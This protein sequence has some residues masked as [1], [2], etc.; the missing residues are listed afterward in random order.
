[1]IAV[2]Y[3]RAKP[4]CKKGKPCGSVC[5]PQKAKCRKESPQETNTG[6][7]GAIKAAGWAVAAAATAA[8]IGVPVATYAGV[9]SRYRE[10]FKESAKMAQSMAKDI[11]PINVKEKQHSVV[12]CVGGMDYG[13][14]NTNP[15]I[16]GRIIS[17]A[18]N[19]SL[20]QKD[21]G[22]KTIPISTQGSNLDKKEKPEG[23][24]QFVADG[25]K[26]TVYKNVVEQG[27]NKAAVRLAAQA[28]A[29]HDKYP[30]KQIVMFGTSMGG[31]IVNEAQEI[32]KQA[33]PS[34]KSKLKSM[35]VGTPYFG[36]TEPWG[37]TTEIA[38]HEDKFTTVLPTRSKTKL[39]NLKHVNTKST[40]VLHGHLLS[41]YF[42]SDE[43]K[44]HL[45]DFIY[46]DV[47]TTKNTKKDSANE[48]KCRTG[49]PC[50]EICIPKTHKCRIGSYSPAKKA[51]VEAVK[52]KRRQVAL[53]KFS[54]AIGVLVAFEAAV[55]ATNYAIDRRN[56]QTIAEEKEVKDDFQSDVDNF[57]DFRSEMRDKARS[58][59][60]GRGYTDIELVDDWY[61]GFPPTGYMQEPIQSENQELEQVKKSLQDMEKKWRDRA[62]VEHFN[63]I[64]DTAHSKNRKKAT[65]DSIAVTNPHY[66]KLIFQLK[67][68][69]NRVYTD[70]IDHFIKVEVDKANTITGLFRDGTKILEFTI[71]G[72]DITYKKAG[73]KNK[74]DSTYYD[75]L[76]LELT[77]RSDAIKKKDK[78][79]KGISCGAACVASNKS[80]RLKAN[81]IASFGELA[82]LRTTA[83]QVGGGTAPT[84]VADQDTYETNPDTGQ[85]Y[86]IRELKKKAS[87]KGVYRYSEMTSDQLKEALRATDK[88]P[89]QQERLG[90]TLTRERSLT[91]RAQRAGLIGKTK[92]EKQFVQWTRE[93][94]K[95]S[96]FAD[97]V[98]KAPLGW[99]MTATAAFL[100][101]TAVRTYEQ[102]KD[103]Y[104]QG[105]NDSARAAEARAVGMDT[106]RVSKEN[107]AFVVGGFN[108]LGH[109]SQKMRELLEE[110]PQL[111]DKNHYVQFDLKETDVPP[112]DGNKRNPDGSYS[113]GYLGYV[114]TRGVGQF[115]KDLTRQRNDDAVELAAQI[116]AHAVRRNA[117]NYQMAHK[118]KS[119]NIVSHSVGGEVVNQAMDILSKMKAVGGKS[120]PTGKE[121]LERVNIVHLSAPD[122][123]FTEN[124]PGNY[125]NITSGQDPFSWMPKRREKWVSTVK[126]NEPE[127]YIRDPEVR[128]Q[129][130]QGFG[131][132]DISAKQRERS[133]KT[134]SRKKKEPSAAK[135]KPKPKPKTKPQGTEQK[136]DAYWEAFN[137]VRLDAARKKAKCKTGKSCGDICIP[138][139]AECHNGLQKATMLAGVVGVAGLAAGA[140]VIALSKSNQPKQQSKPYAQSILD[141]QAQK[142]R[143]ENIRQQ[144]KEV[145]SQVK[146]VLKKSRKR[147]EDAIEANK[148]QEKIEW[149]RKKAEKTATT[150]KSPEPVVLP[151]PAEPE[152]QEPKEHIPRGKKIGVYQ[153]VGYSKSL[154]EGLNEWVDEYE[155]SDN[156]DINRPSTN[157]AQ[158][159]GMAD[160]LLLLAGSKNTQV[161]EKHLRGLVDKDGKLQAAASIEDR[162][163]HI[164]V[165]RLATAPWN[166]TKSQKSTKG[167]GTAMFEAIVREAA[168]Q[169][170]GIR[171][172]TTTSASDFYQ[173]MGLE[174][175]EATGMYYTFTP[176]Q[177]QDFLKKRKSR[178]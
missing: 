17:L 26:R 135:S 86:T 114:A 68:I 172:E 81:A 117:T 154:K 33:K 87:E 9:R 41:D 94:N 80:C 110:D 52:R 152:N 22:L 113:L 95:I 132:Y 57:V 156:P 46:K 62:N 157:Y 173:K 69:L 136:T 64:P 34:M 106:S 162:G 98:G 175:D 164:Y 104:R 133:E 88:D 90:K 12:F 82:Q 120:S 155:K 40:D 27:R 28:I 25:F 141:N 139:D 93:W 99:G 101:G 147:F 131:Y 149:E 166:L 75:S 130:R 85:P 67:T 89:D 45:S 42:Q 128:E 103:H 163:D 140:S 151:K 74:K 122:T 96:K 47:K 79:V 111:T 65:T 14:E 3:D 165:D 91:G 127:D 116:Y 38:A 170:K 158:G 37:E 92:P 71:K 10:G 24:H 29:Y 115:A 119:F 44:K 21:K 72:N 54:A 109:S 108:G 39:F 124:L 100:A 126:G 31:M 144:G 121:V 138:K 59:G 13:H 176:E 43:V 2:R 5:I 125:R 23:I 8:L 77:L 143:L 171:L 178:K 18:V 84:P 32:L 11:E 70:G 177:A 168:S 20:S 83:A 107:I 102:A 105:L 153:P 160:G 53:M 1:M 174:E 16:S 15:N 137:A 55:V 60:V 49:Q 76:A 61:W 35:T 134:R 118:D 66:Q 161:K 169:N 167:A 48:P 7:D 148:E 73:F 36:L 78:C 145:S 146:E 56:E 4:N 129:I 97:Y 50:G 19:K 63:N 123:G 159:F 142:E 51:K 30:D 6:G 150:Q 112:Y 58:W